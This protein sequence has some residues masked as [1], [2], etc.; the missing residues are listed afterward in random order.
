MA[1]TARNYHDDKQFAKSLLNN[2]HVAV[3]PGSAFGEA[4]QG[5]LRISLVADKATLSS[6]IN[7][8][9]TYL[10]QYRE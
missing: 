2:A 9:I 8:L 6:G 5:Y 4:G 1:A 3:V 10:K 7:Q